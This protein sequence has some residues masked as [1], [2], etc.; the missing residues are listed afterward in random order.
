MNKTLER[1]MIAEIDLHENAVY[2]VAGGK[3]ITIENPPLGYG[4]QEISWQNGKP[5]H[6]DI[7]YSKKI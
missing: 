5:T 7:K 2:I 1:K 3:L 4:K 6:F